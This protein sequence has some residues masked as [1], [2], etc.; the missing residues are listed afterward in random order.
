MGSPGGDGHGHR[1][2]PGRRRAERPHAAGAED[3]D[4]RRAAVRTERLTQLAS[5]TLGAMPSSAGRNDVGGDKGE[6]STGIVDA[7]QPRRRQPAELRRDEHQR[8]L[9][10]RRRPAAH[11]QVQHGGAWPSKW[12]TPAASTAETE[13]G[14][15]NVNMVPKDGGNRF[16]VYG[17]RELHQQ[18]TWRPDTC[19]TTSS[20]ARS[21][22]TRTSMKQVW[23]YGLGRRRADQEGQGLV[24]LGQSVVGEPELRREQLLQQVATLFYT[25]VPD[26]SRPAYIDVYQRT[27]AAA[28]PGRRRPK[29]KFTFEQHYQDACVCWVSIGGGELRPKATSASTT[30]RTT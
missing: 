25:Y 9:R 11:L 6:L 8:V 20:L 17:T 13:T 19:R 5:L 28:S 7:R 24:L 2:D 21:T 18:A 27:S 30:R 16:S 29:Q 23:D 12:S 26:P 22:P 4:A 1:R 3:R 14:G 10:R 15:A